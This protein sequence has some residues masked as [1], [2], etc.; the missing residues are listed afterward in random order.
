MS[1]APHRN[2]YAV[3]ASDTW[4]LAEGNVEAGPFVLRY[5]TPILGPDG[6]EGYNRVLR[7]F[8]PYEAEN[9]GALPSTKDSADM[10][11]FENRLCDALEIDA[12]AFLAAVLTFDGARQWVFHT[13]DVGECGRSLEGMPQNADPFPIEIDAFDDPA[14]QYLRTQILKRVPANA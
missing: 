1:I 10:E 3:L 6:V 5:R 2:V 8:W 11:Q 13:L 14:W 7:I 12:H 4:T 9:S